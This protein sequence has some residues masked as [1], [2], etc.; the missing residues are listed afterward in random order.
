[1][2]VVLSIGGHGDAPLMMTPE[3]FARMAIAM[4]AHPATGGQRCEICARRPDND[5][6]ALVDVDG[7]ETCLCESCAYEFG[8]RPMCDVAHHGRPCPVD[9]D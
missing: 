6:F 5:E 2:G 7:H 8:D 1:M 9:A 3:Q 4:E